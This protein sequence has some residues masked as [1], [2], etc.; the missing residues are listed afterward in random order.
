MKDNKKLLYLCIAIFGIVGI[1]LT[2]ISGNI[3]KYDSKAEAYKIDPNESWDSDGSSV[4]YP[5]YYFKVNGKDYQCKSKT[6]SNLLPN[7]NQ[8]TVYY[9]GANPEK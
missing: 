2:F 3:N 7:K 4:Y 1:Y 9:N 8:N 5:I 6:G